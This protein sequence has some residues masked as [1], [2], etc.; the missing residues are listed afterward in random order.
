MFELDW[1]KLVVIGVVALIAIGPKELPTV[2]RTVGQWMGKM[3]RM[4]A[5]FQ[6]QFQEAMREAEMADLKK[7]VDEISDAA[8]G[9][10][11]FDPLQSTPAE[12]T[13]APASEASAA[14]PTTQNSA[15]SAAH[16]APDQ[17]SL[18]PATGGADVAVALPEPVPPV[19]ASDLVTPE[20]RTAAPG[21]HAPDRPA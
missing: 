1:A 6:G 19:T 21:P 20:A 18:P 15:A 10:T 7:H 5:E 12:A 9:L 3:R 8:R 17:A 16:P 14:A 13:T 4:A 2:L 11:T